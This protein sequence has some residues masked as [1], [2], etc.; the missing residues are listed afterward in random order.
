VPA[1]VLTRDTLDRTGAR[2]AREATSWLVRVADPLTDH[3]I[4]RA[5][6]VGSRAGQ[7]LVAGR[8]H[9]DP[10]PSAAAD[11]GRDG[12]DAVAD[13]SLHR[14]LAEERLYLTVPTAHHAAE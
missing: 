4:T 14:P 12:G 3:Q 10:R 8:V 6:E 1:I 5:R 7:L 9:P 11:S 2:L 13:E